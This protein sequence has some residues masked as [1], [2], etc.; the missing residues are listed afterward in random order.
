M[1]SQV[2]LRDID[3]IIQNISKICSLDTELKLKRAKDFYSKHTI[4]QHFYQINVIF[5]MF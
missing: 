3:G 4:R 5:V 1:R 2:D